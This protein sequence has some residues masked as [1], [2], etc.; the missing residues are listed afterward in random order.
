MAAPAAD[1]QARRAAAC[2]GDSF[3]VLFRMDDW[4]PTTG[5][6]GLDA[7]LTGLRLGDNVV[8][9]TD[10]L[11]SYRTYVEALARGAGPYPVHYFRF[12]AH[13]AV[14]GAGPGVQVHA[15]DPEAGFE[16]FI[17]RV[18]AVIEPAGARAY[19]VFDCLSDLAADWYSDT[20]LG[21]FFQLTCPFVLHVG[22]IAYFS[23]RGQTHGARTLDLIQKTAQIVIDLYP[24]RGALFLHPIKVDQRHTP[25]M[26]LL[27]QV[28]G[29]RLVPVNS[30]FVRPARPN[31]A[32]NSC[33]ISVTVQC[34]PDAR[35]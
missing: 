13:A 32:S 23:I 14:L 19:H 3:P 1:W 17:A 26:H 11:A 15:L 30:S 6:A 34:R 22:S 10:S 8:W 7:L 21:S 24:H 5:C 31:T 12:A 20:M 16:D 27:H 33:A 2:R 25:S 28:A 4:S 35:L 18:H 29:D 9:R